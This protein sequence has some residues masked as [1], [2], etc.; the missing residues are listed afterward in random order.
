MAEDNCQKIKL[1]KLMEML[2]QETDEQHPMTKTEVCRRL[3]G[4]GI[5]C[6][7][8]TLSRDMKLLQEQ[9][10]EIMHVMVGHERAYY[11]ADRSFSVPELK[12]LIDAVQA[13]NFIPEGKSEN[14]ISK[15]ATLAG[16]NEAEVLTGNLVRFNTRKHT[17]DRIYYTVQA[18]EAALRQQKKASFCYYDLNENR[19]KIYRKDHARYL[20]DPIALVYT[21]DNYYLMSYSE[22]HKGISNYRLDRMDAVAVEEESVCAKA[23][24]LTAEVGRYTEQVFR[25]F[26]GEP[27][28]VTMEFDPSLIGVVFDKFGETTVI[29]RTKENQCRARVDLQLSPVFY[30]WVFQFAGRMRIIAPKTVKEAFTRQVESC[31]E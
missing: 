19:E 5:S 26:T 7:R 2:R 13:A 15:L 24:S 11:I 29:T 31:R 16:S 20:V 23:L 30:S 3:S 18:L 14:L 21:D 10:Y 9:G 1:L 4:M 22:K 27:K 25:M 8:R 6:D 12:I 17:N 28:T